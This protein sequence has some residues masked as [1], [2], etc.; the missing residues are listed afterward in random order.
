MKAVKKKSKK[1]PTILAG[2][3]KIKKLPFTVTYSFNLK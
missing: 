3:F 1:D 2:P